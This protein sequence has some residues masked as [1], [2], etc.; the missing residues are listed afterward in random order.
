MCRPAA[1]TSS[2]CRPVSGRGVVQSHTTNVQQWSA[3]YPPPYVVAV[4]A[5][6]EDPRD[7]AD[8][9]HRRLRAPTRSRSACRCGSCSST[10]TTCGCRCSSRPASRAVALPDER[11][12]TRADPIGA[13]DGAHREVRGPRR[14]HGHRHVAHRAQ[15]HGAAAVADRRG[16][17]ARR[18]RRRAHDGRHRRPVDLPGDR[19]R[20]RLRR[21][22]R[23]RG[24]VG[25]RHPAD[26]AQR[27]AR[28][29]GRDRLADR[30][31]ARGRRRAVP[32]RRVLPHG[33]AVE[34]RRA[35]RG[36]A[37]PPAGAATGRRDPTSTSR[38]TAC[39]RCTPWRWPRRSTWPAT[40]RPA[41]RWA[42]SRSTPA[43]TPRSNPTALYRDPL[44][45]DDYLAAR[46]ISTPFGLFDC[47]AL[48]DGAVA[49]VVSAA[50]AAADYAAARL[51][52]GGRH[53]DHRAD[54]V[55]P[56]R[57]EPRAA[58]AR[59]GRPRLDA[60]H[61]AAR[62]HRRR[63]ALRR[64]HVQLPVVD[65]GARLLRDRRG[66]GLPRRRQEHRPRRPPAPEHPR[67]AAVARPHPRHGPGARGHRA[68]ARR[69]RRPAGRDA[70][71]AVVTSGGLTPGGVVL[72]RRDR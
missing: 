1:A 51:R 68:A 38:P 18:R 3:E 59:A 70:A 11:D 8:D 23:H 55:G 29:T 21:G 36:A 69:R 50:D 57:A 10:S 62:R 56:G 40:A 49:V 14:G 7:P 25:A 58:R 54:G 31:D 12:E 9:E 2:T 35:G 43:P 24:R 4:V 26:V 48:C 20:G 44:T 5:I 71:T 66:Q 42:G 45:M 67:R 17:A 37:K 30:R 33:L 72:F 15:A 60:H 16:D 41:R 28:D 63:R 64:V 52:R 53:A 65:R 27:R 34:L 19:G 32:P 39:R 46:P 6:D 47:D 61:A 22:R 13:A